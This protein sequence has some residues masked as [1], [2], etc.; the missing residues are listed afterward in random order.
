MFNIKHLTSLLIS[1]ILLTQTTWADSADKI[2]HINGKTMGNNYKVSLVANS[3]TPQQLYL[4]R[5]DIELKLEIVNK[6][7]STWRK[8]SEI[9][10]INAWPADKPIYIS[11]ELKIIILASKKVEKITSG[12]FDITVGPLVKLWGFGPD[13]I[14]TDIPSVD[15]INQVKSYTGSSNFSLMG[16]NYTKKDSRLQLDLSGIAKGH[17]VDILADT[18]DSKG[19]HHYFVD[20]GG[21]VFAKGYRPNKENWIIGIE[22]PKKNST[23]IITT[24]SINGKAIATSGDYRNYFEAEGGKF[25]HVINPKTGRSIQTNIISA[26][27]IAPKCATA[28]ALATASMVMGTKAIMQLADEQDLAVMLIEDNFGELKIHQSKEFKKFIT[29]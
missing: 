26:T 10:K 27:V 18:L 11:N 3:M 4:L 8:D 6:T 2:Y 16:N 19:I 23:H 17:A 20:I 9:S 25:S 1:S 14:P 5:E 15:S 28:D 29:Q 12:A 24:L 22:E 13:G 7:M 21:E